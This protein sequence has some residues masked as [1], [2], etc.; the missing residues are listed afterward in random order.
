MTR[1]GFGDVD[2]GWGKAAYGGPAKG[3][4]G[5]IPGVASFYIPFRDNNGEDGIVVPVCL[6]APAMERFVKELDG[7]LKEK[8]IDL[9]AQTSTT[10]I[11]CAL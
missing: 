3:G 5:A 8:P 7:M 11:K 10:F 9:P 1:A 2:F 6:P 4:V